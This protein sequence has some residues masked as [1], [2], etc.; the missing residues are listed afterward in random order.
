MFRTCATRVATVVLAFALSI[1]ASAIPREPAI[2]DP[3]DVRERVVRLLK[4]IPK[5]LLPGVFDDNPGPPKP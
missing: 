1:S 4:K 2:G 5:I 3:I